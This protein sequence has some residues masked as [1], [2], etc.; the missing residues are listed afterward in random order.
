MQHRC[1]GYHAGNAPDSP[2][3]II[4]GLACVS[5]P[6]TAATASF[7]RSF[8]IASP[9]PPPPPGLLPDMMPRR[10]VIDPQLLTWGTRSSPGTHQQPATNPPAIALQRLI[11]SNQ[12]HVQHGAIVRW[13]WH[14]TSAPSAAHVVRSCWCPSVTLRAG[15]AFTCA[16]RAVVLPSH[17]RYHVTQCFSAAVRSRVGWDRC[18]R[19][20]AFTCNSLPRR[21]PCTSL[22]YIPVC[23]LVTCGLH[24]GKQQDNTTGCTHGSPRRTHACGAARTCQLQDSMLRHP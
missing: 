24:R 19:K 21:N 8:N 23:V 17:W 4:R 5:S 13:H 7:V 12:M 22:L 20:R 2:W 3:H 15:C 11:N 9:S 1:H 18:I 16:V 10:P 6:F 14:S